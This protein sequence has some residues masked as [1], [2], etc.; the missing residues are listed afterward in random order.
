M[1]IFFYLCVGVGCFCPFYQLYRNRIAVDEQLRDTCCTCFTSFYCTGLCAIINRRVVAVK[2]NLEYG[3]I[4][5]VCVILW[6]SSCA[7][8]QGLVAIIILFF[9]FFSYNYSYMFSCR[10]LWNS[11]KRISNSTSSRNSY[12]RCLEFRR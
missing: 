5:D 9:F 11:T 10:G 8:W 3:Q 4:A 2:Y 1:Y 7:I 6:C 12:I